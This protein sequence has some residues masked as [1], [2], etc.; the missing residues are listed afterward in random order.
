MF[1]DLIW[2]ESLV[3]CHMQAIPRAAPGH[4]LAGLWKLA[5]NANDG[6]PWP[7]LFRRGSP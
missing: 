5:L 7:A 6:Y 2:T 4:L 1:R 3:L